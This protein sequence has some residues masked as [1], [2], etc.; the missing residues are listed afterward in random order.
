MKRIILVDT[1]PHM[2]AA[3]SRIVDA[4][5]EVIHGSIIDLDIQS[6]VS[7]ANSFGFMDGGIDLAYSQHFGWRIQEKLQAAIRRKPMGELLV[8]EAMCVPTDGSKSDRPIFNIVCAPTMRVPMLLLPGTVNPYLATKAALLR[9]K[10]YGDG[11]AFPGMG[12]GA[13]RVPYDVAAG[14]MWRAICEVIFDE[15]PA[16][17]ESDHQAVFRHGTMAFGR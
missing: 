8:G 9:S 16:F 10:G 14:Q 6:I 11:I 2:T 5:V 7:P 3:W 17:P 13:G 4:R 1:N 15:M 12:T